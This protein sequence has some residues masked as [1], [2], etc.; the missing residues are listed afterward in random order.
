[1]AVAYVMTFRT[2]PGRADD[3]RAA[4]TA[5][6]GHLRRLGVAGILLEPIAG[7]DIGSLGM[8]L[9]F[10]NYAEFATMFQKVNADQAWQEFLAEAQGDDTDTQTEASL[11]Q[12]M[13]AGFQPAADRPLGV[14]AATQWR[15]RHGHAPQFLAHVEAAIP[16]IHRLGGTT[17]VMQS[18]NGLHPN[19]VMIPVGFAD[20]DAWAAYSD[21]LAVDDQWQAFWAGVM[22]DPSADLVRAGVYLNISG[23]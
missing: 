7:A 21:A 16:H 14:I 3:H 13:D 10:A 4:M 18:V 20:L 8:S 15:T 2:E 9:N 19:T 6:L 5:A 12:D 22:T 17:R 23:D 11:F 1:M